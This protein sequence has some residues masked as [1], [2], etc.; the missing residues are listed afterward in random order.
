MAQDK[1][2]TFQEIL[3]DS[4]EILGEELKNLKPILLALRSRRAINKDEYDTIRKVEDA[5]DQVVELISL[6]EEKPVSSYETFM[7]VL[8]DKEKDIWQKVTEIEAKHHYVREAVPD[9]PDAPGK[10]DVKNVG[11][12][13]IEISWKAPQSDVGSDVT[14]YT[15][16]CRGKPKDSQWGEWQTV[17]CEKVTAHSYNTT[18]DLQRA[19]EYQF[20]VYA[21][22]ELGRSEPSQPSDS[23]IPEDKPDAPG[24]PDVKNVGIKKIEISWKAPQSNGGSDVTGYTIECKRKPEDSQCGE[25]QTLCEKVTALRYSTTGDLQRATEYQFRV[26]AENKL[27]RS[28][29]SQP[30]DSII[31]EDKPDAPAKPDVKN[32]GIKKI[33]ISWKVP[34]NDGGSDVTGYT[35]ECRSKPKDSQWG[36]WQTLCEKAILLSAEVNL[37]T[38]SGVNGRHCVKRYV[39][40]SQQ[41]TCPF[42]G[43]DVTGY[44]I[45]CRSKPKDSQWGEWQTLCEKIPAFS[46]STTEGLERDTQCQFRVCARNKLGLSE[47]SQ[48]SEGII[49]EDKPDAPGKPEVK[50]DG[51][52]KV[53]ISWKAP[54]SDG[55]SPLIGYTIEHRRKT[56]DRQWDQCMWE[57]VM[58]VRKKDTELN[59]CTVEDLE[60]D[61]DYQF[62]VYAVNLRGCSDPSDTSDGITP[63]DETPLEIRLRGADAL[64]AYLE[65]AKEGKKEI[66]SIRLMLVGQERVGKTS[67]VKAFMRDKFESE[68]EITDG[69]DASKCCSVAFANPSVWKPLQRDRKEHIKQ[70]DQKHD[71][72]VAHAAAS[73]LDPTLAD[74]STPLPA[75]E[76]DDLQ[77]KD[78]ET[79]ASPPLGPEDSQNSPEQSKQESDKEKEATGN[80]AATPDLLGKKGDSKQESA[81]LKSDEKEM[82]KKK[83]VLKQLM[84][85]GKGFFHKKSSTPAEVNKTSVEAAVTKQEGGAIPARITKPI[86]ELAKI[87]KPEEG[88]I[89]ERISKP[90][91]QL[92]KTSDQK[93]QPK[94]QPDEIP[95][96]IR[97]AKKQHNDLEITFWDFAGQDLYY[98]THQVFFN[99][100]AVFALVFDMSKKLEESCEVQDF[101]SKEE[102]SRFHDFNGEDF[103]KFWLQSIYTYAAQDSA[104][105]KGYPP[106]FIIGTHK[107]DSPVEEEAVKRKI[108][109]ILKEKKYEKYV[110]RQFHFLENDPT[111]KQP[112]DEEAFKAT[113]VAVAKAAMNAPHMKEKYPIKWL[114]FH[115]AVIE[116]C[117]NTPYMKLDETRELAAECDITDESQFTTMLGLYHDLGTI[118]WFGEDKIL[119]NTVIL[120]P[121]WLIDVFKAVITVLPDEKQDP[122]FV[123][124][125][126]E[127]RDHGILSNK[128]IEHVWVKWIGIKQELLELMERFDMLF[129]QPAQ[130]MNGQTEEKGQQKYCVPACLHPTEGNVDITDGI[131]YVDFDTFLPDGFFHRVLVHF[132]RWS[133]QHTDK[134]PELFYRFCK[135]IVGPENKRHVCSLQMIQSSEKNSACIKIT[136]KK[137][138]EHG[139]TSGSSTG[140]PDPE[141]CTTVFDFMSKTLHELR[142]KW[143]KGIKY[144]VTVGC[145]AC[146]EE[147]KQKLH[148]IPMEECGSG[149]YLCRNTDTAIPAKRLYWKAD[150]GVSSSTEKP[151]PK[152]GRPHVMISY[153]WGQRKE[154]QKR[155]ITL[156]DQLQTAGFQVWLDVDEMRGNMDDRMAEAVDGAFVILLCFSKDY[157]KS[158][159]C[160]K[161]PSMQST[162]ENQ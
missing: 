15:I 90:M 50:N 75:E 72:G 150:T 18:G 21:E 160:K 63:E 91:E 159:S 141:V 28:E 40:T 17:L 36:E 6:L 31:P 99:R 73:Q 8:H 26:Y 30:S 149:S 104:D 96:S 39:N 151:K 10:P 32:V 57:P 130:D 139:K 83:T 152:Q 37:K 1:Q 118:I 66:R 82:P 142:D 121:Q 119:R 153:S 122:K 4:L 138:A 58:S 144:T 140:E 87:S 22:N 137:V 132:A 38:V 65:A 60:A 51:I 59:N 103:I 11:I 5:G 80:G 126:Q 145:V 24:K 100:R 136:L 76:K 92:A 120:D 29:P 108:F 44:T 19:T 20:R 146:R 129:R 56:E 47:P 16:E 68:E 84:S 98:T 158:G 131:F 162:K 106:I 49:P 133:S 48:P 43:S 117:D 74:E 27:G 67:L 23:I 97:K 110:R 45:E 127:L 89:P 71:W 161:R 107:R 115:K 9:K 109:D 124:M 41:V 105:D 55:G 34:Q 85:R 70:L 14:G 79:L 62:H 157:Q 3:E 111:K 53:E 42:I 112:S 86:E 64:A 156:R 143:A 13:K 77:A 135:S 88:V 35:I 2:E 81:V 113:K 54:Q 69:V 134:A 114:Q 7:Q 116:S 128:L 148:L 94:E 25:W 102:T 46:Y 78:P 95:E 147:G 125:W 93:R 61:K 33:E 52:K 154:C 12:K 123:K 101:S 155:M